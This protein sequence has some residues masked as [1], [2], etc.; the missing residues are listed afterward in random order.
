M[1]VIK[2][3]LKYVTTIDFGSVTYETD[4]FDTLKETNLSVLDDRLLKQKW[5]RG[6]YRMIATAK[7]D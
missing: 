1:E 2:P 7:A 4:F 3:G 5:F 6:E